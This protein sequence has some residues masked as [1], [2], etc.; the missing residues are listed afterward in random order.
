MIR[1]SIEVGLQ[2]ASIPFPILLMTSSSYRGLSGEAK[3]AYAFLKA[4]LLEHYQCDEQGN[5]YVQYPPGRLESLL[6]HSTDV[7]EF[8]LKELERYD[9]LEVIYEESGSRIYLGELSN[10]EGLIKD[11]DSQTERIP[12][13]SSSY[14]DNLEEFELLSSLPAIFSKTFLTEKTLM[15]IGKSSATL[16]EAKELINQV[17]ETKRMVEANWR[18]VLNRENIHGIY[19]KITGEDF[20]MD[21]EKCFERLIMNEKVARHSKKPIKDRKAFYRVSLLNFWQTVV[22]LSNQCLDEQAY[23]TLIEEGLP[24][25]AE[26]DTQKMKKEYSPQRFESQ[27]YIPLKPRKSTKQQGLQMHNWLGEHAYE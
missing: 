3:V 20:S 26:Y 9:L 11:K 14:Q 2:Q 18:R 5:A 22:R 15:S 21:L 8:I 27:V 7:I 25:E 17:Y 10:D 13:V 19:P 24:P 4:D 16:K 12:I 6:H 23:V 1:T